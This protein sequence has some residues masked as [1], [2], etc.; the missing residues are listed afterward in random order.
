VA[1][2]L[3]NASEAASREDGSLGVVVHC[4]LL[5]RKFGFCPSV[6]YLVLGPSGFEARSDEHIAGEADNERNERLELFTTHDSCAWC[7]A[8]GASRTRYGCCVYT[9]PMAAAKQ[10]WDFRV[11]P[12]T[13]RLVRQAAESTQRTLTNFVIDAAV[14]EAERLL[15]DRTQ[16]V[17]AT[18]Q[19]DQF[20]SA[21]D[22]PPRDNPGLRGL[23]AKPSVFSDA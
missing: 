2:Q 17:L 22:R 10:R 18:E 23:F 3:L 9:F 1:Q 12:D 11:E 5:P 19:W 14:I 4:V 16:F 15:A 6:K 20:V 13:D 7:I 21:L 8:F